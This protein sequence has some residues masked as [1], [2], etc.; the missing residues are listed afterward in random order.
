MDDHSFLA[1]QESIP[2]APP[3]PA[4]QQSSQKSTMIGSNDDKM[5]KD[6]SS[7]PPTR[8]A[9]H[10]RKRQRTIRRM[11]TLRKPCWIL[12][13]SNHMV[14]VVLRN[15]HNQKEAMWLER[16]G[17]SVGTTIAT[18]VHDTIVVILIE[19][20]GTTAAATT[21]QQQPKSTKQ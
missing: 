5:R 18:C 9:F 1:T 4:L 16:F 12:A 10:K 15:T 21:I 11:T 6:D 2:I 13:H 19:P 20:F 7:P 14:L 8:K 17:G 3:P